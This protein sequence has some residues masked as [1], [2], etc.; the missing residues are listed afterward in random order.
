MLYAIHRCAFAFVCAA[1]FTTSHQR[2]QLHHSRNVSS[3][4]RKA[5]RPVEMGLVLHPQA[6]PFNK[7]GT[8]LRILL[9]FSK[10]SPMNKF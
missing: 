9:I 7:I 10:V 6:V 2:H 5:K 8:M 3:A 4:H 1:V